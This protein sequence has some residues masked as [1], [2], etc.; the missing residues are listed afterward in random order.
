MLM[1]RFFD[2]SHE[3]PICGQL[4]DRIHGMARPLPAGLEERAKAHVSHHHW[5]N[6]HRLCAICGKY[7][8]SGPDGDLQCAINDGIKIHPDYTEE[9]FRK[10]APNDP[11]RLL[12]VH[13]Q[14]VPAQG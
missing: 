11:S 10:V 6:Q 4:S 13:R 2:V 9:G 12:I 14:C 7:V 8:R 5:C 3:C 1:E